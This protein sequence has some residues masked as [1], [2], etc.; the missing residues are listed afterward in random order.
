[1]EMLLDTSITDMKGWK[2]IHLSW[3]VPVSDPDFRLRGGTF[4]HE[5]KAC[6]LFSTDPRCH[7]TRFSSGMRPT[8]MRCEDE[9]DE[10][11]LES[12]NLHLDAYLRRAGWHIHQNGR[13]ESG[14][15]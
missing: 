14:P 9:K 2:A 8:Q 13:R 12:S 15:A 6:P 10:D 11:H 1:V 3:R 4:G 7:D 5:S